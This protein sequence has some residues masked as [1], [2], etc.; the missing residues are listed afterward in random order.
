MV[1]DP[2]QYRQSGTDNNPYGRMTPQNGPVS[3]FAG[4]ALNDSGA[5][6]GGTRTAVNPPARRPGTPGT[7]TPGSAPAQGSRA[8][9]PQYADTSRTGYMFDPANPQRAMTNALVSAGMNPFS[10]NPIL[11][12][13]MAAAPGLANSFMV[14]GTLGSQG[15]TD[16]EA[17]AGQGGLGNIFKQFLTGAISGGGGGI[18]SALRNYGS[19]TSDTQNALQSAMGVI[20]RDQKAGATDPNG[21]TG[22]VFAQTLANMIQND[23]TNGAGLIAS[24]YTPFMSP[25]MSRAYGGRMEQLGYLAPNYQD[26][27]NLDDNPFNYL[28]GRQPGS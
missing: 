28:I 5:A 7:G 27:T 11:R 12:N 10:M 16:A 6:G 8:V 2:W 15:G 3:P 4:M 13:L 25:T 18:S 14:R 21:F 23:P 1:M 26:W 19:G 22:N 17:I 20:D 24:L 9:D